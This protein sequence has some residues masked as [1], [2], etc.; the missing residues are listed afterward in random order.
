VKIPKFVIFFIISGHQR[1]KE[2]IGGEGDRDK[3]ND[4][5]HMIEPIARFVEGQIS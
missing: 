3:A 4:F 5:N 2:E 1:Q